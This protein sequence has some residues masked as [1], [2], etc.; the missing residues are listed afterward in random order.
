MVLPNPSNAFFKGAAFFS[1]AALLVAGSPS[2]SS[3]SS[4]DAGLM[5]KCVPLSFPPS[6]GSRKVGVDVL[7]IDIE[8]VQLTREPLRQPRLDATANV[9]GART[10]LPYHLGHILSRRQRARRKRPQGDVDVLQVDARPFED[11][12]VQEGRGEAGCSAVGFR[13]SE[14]QELRTDG[15]DREPPD[16]LLPEHRARLLV[17]VLRRSSIGIELAFR[18]DGQPSR[19]EIVATHPDTVVSQDEQAIRAV[20]VDLDAIGIGVVWRS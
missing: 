11:A 7:R 19:H 2:I 10:K 18:A 5:M 15:R 13:A 14:D 16:P 3:A 17:R 9:F 4:G 8:S 12:P 1:A 6:D 20:V